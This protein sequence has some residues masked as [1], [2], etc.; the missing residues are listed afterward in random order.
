MR[1]TSKERAFR[2]GLVSPNVGFA[3]RFLKKIMKIQIFTI[4]IVG[5]EEENALMNNFLAS[6]RVIDVQQQIVADKYWTFCVRYVDKMPS[7]STANTNGKREKVDY[8]KVLD[9][10]TFAKFAAIRA[11]RKQ[12]ATEK[13]IPAFAIFTDAELAEISKLEN[14]SVNTIAAISGIGEKRAEEYAVAIMDVLQNLQTTK[15][16]TPQ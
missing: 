11:W 2:Q 1:G 15:D 5:G 14:L 8:R 10:Q 9:E 6:H 16:E 4:P 12:A 13:A 7:E 3:D